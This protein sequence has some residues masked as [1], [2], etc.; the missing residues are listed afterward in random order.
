MISCVS[1]FDHGAITY[2]YRM[3]ET[4]K[5]DIS[6]CFQDNPWVQDINRYRSYCDKF[7]R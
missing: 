5:P 2:L 1:N 4:S 6:K 7:K 3:P